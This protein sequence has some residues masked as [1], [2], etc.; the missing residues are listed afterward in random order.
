M[1][2]WN[3][4]GITRDLPKLWTE[5]GNKNDIKRLIYLDSEINRTKFRISQHYGRY[6]EKG[7]IKPTEENTELA[8]NLTEYLCDVHLEPIIKNLLYERYR[9]EKTIA[10][11]ID[12]RKDIIGGKAFASKALYEDSFAEIDDIF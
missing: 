1:A 4:K 3:K 6:P 7:N 2:Y 11:D 12:S 10:E 8:N 5:Y 9:L